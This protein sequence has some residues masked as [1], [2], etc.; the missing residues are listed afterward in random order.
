[1]R[2]YSK[3]IKLPTLDNSFRARK[4]PHS[5]GTSNGQTPGV[6]PREDVKLSLIRALL[7]R[8]AKQTGKPHA[9]AV[10]FY[11]LSKLFPR[12]AIITSKPL[13]I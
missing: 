7:R 2:D 13:Y 5:Q 8:T 11:R 4:L 10:L 1:M 3:S 6:S 9:L 12:G